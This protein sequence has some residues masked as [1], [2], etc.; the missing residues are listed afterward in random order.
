MSQMT[1]V[2]ADQ[3][4]PSGPAQN[5]APSADL[6]R[7]KYG[8]WL[9]G[10]A[11]VLLVA[12]LGIAVSKFTAAADVTAVVGSVAAVVGTII[13]AF[14]GVQVGSSGKEVAEAGRSQAENAARLA[15]AKLNPNDANDVM[16]ML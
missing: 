14:F 5:L 2:R 1:S 13:G 12:V 3:A 15:L 11:F 16:R 7:I 8:A 9:I 10:A 4:A 6:A